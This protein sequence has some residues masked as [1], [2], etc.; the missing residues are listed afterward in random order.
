MI[1]F[2]KSNKPLFIA[3]IIFLLISLGLVYFKYYAFLYTQVDLAIFS[4]ALRQPWSN[5]LYSTIQGNSFFSYHF[6]PYLILIK[7]FFDLFGQSPLFLVTLQCLIIS[8]AAIPL[9]LIL[10]RTVSAPYRMPMVILFL[11]N[12]TTI[13]LALFEFHP[14][15]L[16]L[17]LLLFLFYFY[18]TNNFQ[19]FILLLVLTM[20]VREDAFLALLPFSLL[21]LIDRKKWPWLAAPLISI[22]YLFASLKI[23]SYLH[24]VKN[25][26]YLVYYAWLGNSIPEIAVNFFLRFPDV[27]RKLATLNVAEFFLAGFLMYFF[28]PLLRPKYLLLGAL[29]YLFFALGPGQGVSIFRIHHGLVFSFSLLISSIYGWQYL[30]RRF[31]TSL[32]KH[33]AFGLIIGAVLLIFLNLSLGTLGDITKVSLDKN[34]WNRVKI[35]RA[36]L[37]GIDRSLP[38]LSSFQFLPYLKTEKA[39]MLSYALQKKQQ[40]LTGSYILPENLPQMIID[41]NDLVSF[42]MDLKDEDYNQFAAELRNLSDRLPVASQNGSILVFKKSDKPLALYNVEGGVSK[43]LQS[44]SA[45]IS[46][47]LDVLKNDGS[48]SVNLSFSPKIPIVKNYILKIR[49]LNGSGEELGTEYHPLIWGMYPTRDWQ[50]GQTYG[51]TINLDLPSGM[52]IEKIGFEIVDIKGGTTINNLDSNN[53]IIFEEKSVADPL[54]VDVE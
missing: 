33:Y 23:I 22:P 11:F 34:F 4:N 47:K 3:V 25:S 6:I 54:F 53:M 36:A 27:I 19:R 13:N 18:L 35:Q 52:A 21:A 1:K 16:M 37:A 31:E 42:K 28:L 41:V 9:K 5:L 49:Y 14:E 10:D 29:S 20:L 24:P 46:G 50:P 48:L 17:P 12:P 51:E 32:K 26:I 39:Y 43:D 2:W 40:Y 7:P 15:V 30:E 8:A 44:L 38:T 45:E